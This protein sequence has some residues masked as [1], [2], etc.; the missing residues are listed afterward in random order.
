MVMVIDEL[1]KTATRNLIKNRK[2]PDERAFDEYRNIKIKTN[3]ISAAEGSADVT[4]G[5]TRVLAGVKVELAEPFPD[6]PEQY[7]I[8][9]G[10]RVYQGSN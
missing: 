3:V 9:P 1:K 5:K 6:R 4:L 7:S 8:V 10:Q 2:R